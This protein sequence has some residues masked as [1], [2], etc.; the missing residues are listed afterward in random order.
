MIANSSPSLS[1][2]LSEDLS[3]GAA[4]DL[5]QELVKAVAEE[6]LG[7]ASDLSAVARDEEARIGLLSS[8][9]HRLH[10]GF[11]GVFVK[12]CND[13]A[14]VSGSFWSRAYYYFMECG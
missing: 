14:D 1:K 13:C 12:T 9:L 4:A 6:K 10:S 7:H 8:V 2:S 11:L 5:R 3:K